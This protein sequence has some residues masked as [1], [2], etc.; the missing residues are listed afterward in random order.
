MRRKRVIRV[1]DNTHRLI[2][3]RAARKGI[4]MEKY[5]DEGAKKN[6]KC[7]LDELDEMFW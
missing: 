2:K 3:Q 1:N 6:R 5:M 7:A 4:S